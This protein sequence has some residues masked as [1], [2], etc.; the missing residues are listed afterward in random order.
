MTDK[1]ISL[2]ECPEC[3]EPLHADEDWRI[4]DKSL[5]GTEV[6]ESIEGDYAHERCL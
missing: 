2:P 1:D 6:G 5:I 4:T 3:G